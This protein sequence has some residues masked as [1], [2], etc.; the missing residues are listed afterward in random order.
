[1]ADVFISYKAE[2]RRAARH[3]SK[4]LAAHGFSVWYDYGLIPGEDFE[5]RLEAELGD[6]KAIIVL[7][8]AMS[9]E[10]PWVQKEAR[11]ARQHGKFLPCWIEEA[12]LPSEFSGADTIN[13]VTWDGGPRSHV[14]DRLIEDLGRRLRRDPQV[15]WRE[16]KDLEDDWRGFGAPTLAQFALNEAPA[17]VRDPAPPPKVAP[18]SAATR[19]TV[20]VGTPPAGLSENLLSHW[21]AAQRNEPGSIAHVAW[22]YSNANGGLPQD[23]VEAVR[24]YRIA[25]D[26]GDPLAQCNLGVRYERGTGG[27]PKDQR[28]SA[29]LYRL[30]ADQGFAQGQANLA[31]LYEKGQG[32]LP[33]DEREA[34]RLY[35]LAADQ[36][37]A[38]AQSNLG[39]MYDDGRGGLQKDQAQAVRLYKQA[40][41]QGHATGQNNLGWMYQEGLGGLEKNDKES[42]RLYRLAAE[43]GYAYAQCNLGVLYR[44]GKG[45]LPQDD[46]EAVRLFKLGSEQGN[47]ESHSN[48]GYMYANGRGGLAKDEA[49]AVRLY[50]LAAQAGDTWSQNELKR[51]NETW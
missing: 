32:G 11:F 18:P 49:E 20:I 39:L 46:R 48:L 7:W 33:K 29:R 26:L 31:I 51:R 16:L 43:Q 12:K 37:N 9:V 10:S 15:N 50:K 17:T 23:E 13:L 19:P 27:L 35:K 5:P 21:R 34:V 2:R 1:M 3:L 30:S 4:V 47:K 22:A 42:V 41:D 8:C 38:S 28:E 44:D 6:S 14:L 45:G 36:G 25:A 24:L 40:A